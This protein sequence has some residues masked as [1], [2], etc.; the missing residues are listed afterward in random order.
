MKHIGTQTITTS[1][2]V[3][4][5]FT[6]DDTQAVWANWANDPYVTEYLTWPPHLSV[7]VT[8]NVLQD[9]VKNYGRDNFYQWA[10]VLK[11]IGEPIGS[12]SVVGQRDDTA[13]V[14]IGYCIGKQWWN[15]GYTGEA[16]AALISF[17]FERVGISR[18]ESRHDPNNPNSGRVM[19]KCG[20]VYEGTLR[21]ADINNKGICDACYYAILRE[22]Y[23]K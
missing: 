8:G 3:L 4:R 10:I 14:H 1:R 19:K 16:L 21:H 12:I 13:M 23:K 22:E 18:I 9:W 17:F 2:L 15:M 7:E 20:M 5:R 6:L 11:D